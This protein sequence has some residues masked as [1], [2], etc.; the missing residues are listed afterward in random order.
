MVGPPVNGEFHGQ[1][2]TGAP[3]LLLR[4]RGGR[5]RRGRTAEARAE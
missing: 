4:L 1:P 2:S 3:S 5:S